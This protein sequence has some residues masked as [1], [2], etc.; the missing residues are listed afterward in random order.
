MFNRLIGSLHTLF[1]RAISPSSPGPAPIITEVI[2]FPNPVETSKT[3]LIQVK[4]ESQERDPDEC[5]IGSIQW[6]VV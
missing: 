1:N 3:Y 6:R 2:I 4:V 5:P